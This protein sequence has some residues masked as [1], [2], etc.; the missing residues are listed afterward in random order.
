MA[1]TKFKRQQ[2]YITHVLRKLGYQIK[3]MQIITCEFNSYEE[4]PIGERYYVGQLIKRGFNI[5]FKL[6]DNE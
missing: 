6:F 3:D 5:Q 4:I 2:Y 1:I